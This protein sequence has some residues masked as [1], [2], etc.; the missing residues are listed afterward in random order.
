MH[1]FPLTDL[2]LSL[3]ANEHPEP[4]SLLRILQVRRIVC[5]ADRQYYCWR[6][7]TIRVLL[8]SHAKY[9]DP[10]T[11]A[12][13]HFTVMLPCMLV[14]DRHLRFHPIFVKPPATLFNTSAHINL[15]ARWIVQQCP[16]HSRSL[17]NDTHL[18]GPQDSSHWP[19]QGWLP[20][21][22]LPANA[23]IDSASISVD[24]LKAERGACHPPANRNYSRRGCFRGGSSHSETRC[25]SNGLQC[26]SLIYFVLNTPPPR[27]TPTHASRQRLAGYSSFIAHRMLQRSTSPLILEQ[28]CIYLRPRDL[29]ISALCHKV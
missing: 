26:L 28:Y 7:Q 13:F 11:D 29:H 21:L 15:V 14:D 25:K 20:P 10:Q 22:T 16:P 23:R 19:Q 24:V 5:I 6:F 18:Q 27:S 8:A 12:G 4:G 17:G 3:V 1:S 9:Q 2:L